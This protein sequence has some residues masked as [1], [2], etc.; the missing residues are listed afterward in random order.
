MTDAAACNLRDLCQIAYF[1]GQTWW[2]YRSDD[3][4]VATV[5]RPGF[6]EPAADM[7]R[8]GDW[9]YVTAR[10]PGATQYDQVLTGIAALPDGTL[11]LLTLGSTWMG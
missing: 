6:F 3:F 5:L 1:H 2:A 11:Q 8:A 7:L 10:A 4:D 9:M